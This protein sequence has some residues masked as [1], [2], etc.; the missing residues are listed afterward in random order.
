[1]DSPGWRELRAEADCGVFLDCPEDTLRADL[2]GRK[3][4][5]GRTYEDAAAHYDL[6]D[7][8]TWQL[9]VQRRQGVDVLIRVGKG[10][11]LELVAGDGSS[12]SGKA[13][14]GEL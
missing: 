2:L 1:L 9:T 7:H 12:P 10:R 6:V 5:Q 3:Q 14:Q 11:R 8:Y 13:G 4:R